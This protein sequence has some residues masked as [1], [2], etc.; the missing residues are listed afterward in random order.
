MSKLR[1]D[2]IYG[3]RFCRFQ[4]ETH[5]PEQVR[6]GDGKGGKRVGK[7]GEIRCDTGSAYED[8]DFASVDALVK[9]WEML[10]LTGMLGRV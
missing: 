4:H 7:R 5:V 10:W 3:C 9:Y 8:I 2:R 1:G 6:E